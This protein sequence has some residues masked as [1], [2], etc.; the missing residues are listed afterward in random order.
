MS[1]V[2][3]T[4]SWR[5]R[6]QL[7]EADLEWQQLSDDAL[8]KFR[9][10]QGLAGGSERLMDFGRVAR[11]AK[12]M[13]DDFL[14]MK[15][16][17]GS[18]QDVHVVLHSTYLS[19]QKLVG[20]VHLLDDIRKNMPNESSREV[21]IY[22]QAGEA[23]GISI[24]G[25][26]EHDLP[27][28]ISEIKEGSPTD[29]SCAC[30][31]GDAIEEIQ[32]Y[33]IKD[34][35]HDLAANV[36]RSTRDA[37][38]V[39]LK[40]RFFSAARHRILSHYLRSGEP[41]GLKETQSKYYEIVRIP[42]ACSHVSRFSDANSQ[43]REDSSFIVRAATDVAKSVILRP[44]YGE[45]TEAKKWVK[46]LREARDNLPGS[47]VRK[48][49]PPSGFTGLVLRIGRVHERLDNGTWRDFFMALTDHDV[50]F[51]KAVPCNPTDFE[52]AVATY[53]L[54]A[55]RYVTGK[56]QL[57]GHD[58]ELDAR[59]QEEGTFYIRLPNGK[60]HYFSAGSPKCEQ[61]WQRLFQERCDNAVRLV[62]SVTYSAFWQGEPVA[63]TLNW[64][65]GLW[66]NHDERGDRSLVWHHPFAHLAQTADELETRTL[67]LDFGD[68]GGAQ[69]LQVENPGMVVFV[70]SAF[71]TCHVRSKDQL[72]E[73]GLLPL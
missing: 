23:L 66:L 19:V 32:D 68:Y 15:A 33:K 18:W 29:R 20:E 58:Q 51:H 55:V 50:S 7:K 25:G 42:L 8:Q 69:R 73:H 37:T 67:E 39:R 70:M 48:P 4:R 34:L 44:P 16:A 3:R 47:S 6:K 5:R 14:M 1:R 62:E 38:A 52:H 72:A 21:T 30:Y 54:L 27:I 63:L 35:A 22:K 71:I 2:F 9:L 46:L 53:P 61:S 60:R 65:T 57:D 43:L 17:D 31:V 56:R 40:L 11:L 36:I 49:H 28:L 13:K 26:L 24:R 10:E 41:E 64:Q 45:D 59:E 12:P